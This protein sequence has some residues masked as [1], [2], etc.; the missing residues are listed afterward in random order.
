[1][2]FYQAYPL[3]LFFYGKIVML[4]I[5]YNYNDLKD[6]N[7]TFGRI[8]KSIIMCCIN[9]FSIS[10]SRNLIRYTGYHSCSYSKI[11]PHK[12]CERTC[13]FSFMLG[14]EIRTYKNKYKIYLWKK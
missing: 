5:V 6:V 4:I 3:I 12:S 9:I 7:N 8:E 14:V 1:M 11:R 10:L 13:Y 2:Y